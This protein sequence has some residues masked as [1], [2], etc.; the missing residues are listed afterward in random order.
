MH[1]RLLIRGTM[2]VSIV[3]FFFSSPSI[4]SSL[5]TQKG[6]IL[7]YIQGKLQVRVQ[8]KFKN[9][10]VEW[11][12]LGQQKKIPMKKDDRRFW[13]ADLDGM[14]GEYRVIDGPH[15]TPWIP[16]LNQKGKDETFTFVV[17][18]SNLTGLG[19]P[20]IHKNLLK[21]M[22]EENPSLV[23][24]TGGLVANGGEP[25]F[26]NQF[27]QEGQNLFQS[28]P[29][30][31]VLGRT[32]RSKTGRFVDNTDM[33][34]NE[35]S[36]YHY[37]YGPAHFIALDT[38]RN[39]SPGGKQYEFLVKTLETIKGQSPIIVYFYHPPFSASVMGGDQKVLEHLVPLFEDYGV[40]L[41]LSGQEHGYQRTQPINGVVYVVTGGGGAI[42]TSISDDPN[43]AKYNSLYHYMV[44][45]VEGD[46]LHGNMKGPRGVVEDSFEWNH[47]ANPIPPSGRQ[48]WPKM[49]KSKRYR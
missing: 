45:E 16:I 28:I 30:Q 41:V 35:K 21:T 13:E 36:R 20:S 4:A 12:H 11:R 42:L 3:L 24:H 29:L 32:D 1:S 18:G 7:H 26:W 43:L 6:P 15:A 23:L 46:T 5:K 34:D 8:G 25:L 44:F 14:E 31:P 33:G 17:Y 9:P 49:K 2:A 47:R 37:R 19:L 48:A 10:I 27:F 40:D 38:T 22:R 39:F